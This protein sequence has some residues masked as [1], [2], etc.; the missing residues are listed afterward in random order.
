MCMSCQLSP[1]GQTPKVKTVKGWQEISY[2]PL[3]GKGWALQVTAAVCV[4]G[5]GILY[6]G[7]HLCSCSSELMRQTH[8]WDIQKPHG[9]T[10]DPFSA[11]VKPFSPW[12]QLVYLLQSV[13][14]SSVNL[15]SLLQALS[16]WV[17]ALFPDFQAFLSVRNVQNNYSAMD[18][19]SISGFNRLNQSLAVFRADC[20]YTFACFHAR[21][22]LLFSYARSMT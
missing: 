11:S 3:H 21:A 4:E 7:G 8:L 17:W 9:H 14:N 22:F 5:R 13:Q 15:L 12:P 20:K 10:H 1:S 19:G 18:S 16:S 2:K 6:A